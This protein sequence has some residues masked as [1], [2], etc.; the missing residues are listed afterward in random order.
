MEW[1]I[2]SASIA[3]LILSFLVWLKNPKEKINKYFGIFGIVSF[4]WIF[5]NFILRFYPS[6]YLMR[7][8]YALGA[9]VPILTLFWCYELWEEKFTKLKKLIFISAGLTFAIVSEVTELIFSKI[10]EVSPLGYKGE[11]GFGFF[12]YAYYMGVILIFIAYKTFKT[13]K[14]AS[15]IKKIQLRY[16]LIGIL[17]YITVVLT[18]SFIFP[19]LGSFKYTALDSP[20]IF[21]FL[22]FT[23]YAVLKHH[24][25]D[26]KVI[27]TEI[28]SIFISL[29]L[30]VNALLAKSLNDFLLKFTLFLT[31]SFFVTLLIKSVLREVRAKEK[32]QNLAKDL[33]TAN[34]ELK[35]LDKAKSEFLSIASHQLRTPLTAIKGYSSMITEGAFGDFSEGV[36]G[37]VKKIFES[38]QQL[39]LMIDDFLDISRIE[40]GK[41]SYEFVTFNLEDLVKKIVKDF[42]E[43]NEKTRELNLTCAVQGQNFLIRGDINKINQVI[44]N[45]LD[46]AIK[47]T[48]AGYVKVYLNKNNKNNAAVLTIKDT[49]IGISKETITKLFQKFSRAEKSSLLN[50]SGSG[51]GLYVAKRIITDHKGR[52]WVESD[53][54][55][56]GSSF[57][58]ELPLS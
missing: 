32:I 48:P 28:F 20:S 8:A 31:S 15:G 23:A 14:N 25:F 38:S 34:T 58:V 52:I 22:M 57:F 46:N 55:G 13:S 35:R 4:L 26:V 18:T 40:A 56:R 11:M 29:V 39:V 19:I 16:V 45:L 53:G 10:V 51:L 27:A 3:T 33:E 41:M 9:L 2:F 17:A 37:A 42:L 30:F 1:I 7:N 43:N 54:L 21:I 36:K 24:L 49:G 47:Y 12:V 44:T 50:T 6:I 5:N